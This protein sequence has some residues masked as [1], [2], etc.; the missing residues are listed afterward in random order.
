MYLQ[1][2][3]D[4]QQT[5]TELKEFFI[6]TPILAHFEEDRETVVEGDSSG[7]ATSAVLP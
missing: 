6:N 1:W 3:D 4:C 7:W 5:F 2:D